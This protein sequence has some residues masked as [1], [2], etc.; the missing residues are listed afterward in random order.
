MFSTRDIQYAPPIAPYHEYTPDILYRCYFF[1]RTDI[2]C[3]LQTQLKFQMSDKCVFFDR[4]KVS[5]TNLCSMSG[6]VEIIEHIINESHFCNVD[7]LLR[8]G[9]T[10]CTTALRGSGQRETTQK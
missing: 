1:S 7:S 10:W 5:R 2:P 3:I 6:W 4:E 8:R 9:S